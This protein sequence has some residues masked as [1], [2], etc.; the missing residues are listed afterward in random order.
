M[1]AELRRDDTERR[2]EI[3]CGKPAKNAE[4][5]IPDAE[6]NDIRE[7]LLLNV[8]DLLA[9]VQSRKGAF[10]VVTSATVKSQQKTLCLVKNTGNARRIRS[11]IIILPKMGCEM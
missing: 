6:R 10:R 5:S 7:R 11:F 9:W 2:R 4:W 3:R 1:D 8:E